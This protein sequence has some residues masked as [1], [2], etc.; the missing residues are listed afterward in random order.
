MA[1]AGG[2]PKLACDAPNPPVD[3]KPWNPPDWDRFVPKPV[4]AVGKE[5][6]AGAGPDGAAAPELN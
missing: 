6:A 2:A 3:P 5:A 4:E 1:A